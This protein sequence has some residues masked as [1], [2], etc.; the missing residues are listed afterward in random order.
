M[1][2]PVYEPQSTRRLWG[3]AFDPVLSCNADTANF[4]NLAFKVRIQ[5]QVLT[6]APVHQKA[7]TTI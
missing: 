3:Y 7:S 6:E 5:L 2:P 1:N 4:I